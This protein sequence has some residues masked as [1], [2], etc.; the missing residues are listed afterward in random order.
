MKDDFIIDENVIL[1]VYRGKDEHN[2]SAIKE[3]RFMYCLLDSDKKLVSTPKIQ[4]YYY[5]IN[6]IILKEKGFMD[7]GF[8]KYFFD[9]L[10]DS[11]K[12][13]I[14]EGLKPNSK[15]IKEGDDE[16]VCLAIHRDGNLVTKDS[17]MKSEIEQEG[18]QD[19]VKYYSVSDAIPLVCT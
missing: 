16:F 10:R 19:Q 7:V 6:K 11:N 2:H 14:V 3:R 5:H 4:S 17:R 12:S 18:L 9:R 8:L 15:Y 1:N 13:P